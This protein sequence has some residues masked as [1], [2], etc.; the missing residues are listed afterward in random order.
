M[1]I[2]SS[3]RKG[4]L[5]TGR[6]PPPVSKALGF[7]PPGKEGMYLT[8]TIHIALL[9]LW[10]VLT[11][12]NLVDSVY[13]PSPSKLFAAFDSFIVPDLDD[14]ISRGLFQYYSFGTQVLF[15]MTRIYASFAV[16]SV[17]AVFVGMLAS[18]SRW[19]GKPFETY[20]GFICVIP[21]I[22][23][24]SYM[25]AVAIFGVP[26]VLFLTLLF[27]FC[28]VANASYEVANDKKYR[29]YR[30]AAKA[31]GLSA[32]KILFLVEIP[33]AASPLLGILR[34]E[35]FTTIGT[36]Y[37]AEYFLA[38]SGLGPILNAMQQGP[39]MAGLIAVAVTCLLTMLPGHF[40]LSWLA[41]RLGGA[42]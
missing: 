20:I 34:V 21:R 19:L 37:F 8:W 2:P 32:V 27:T 39:N 22:V 28:Y 9:M 33:M 36:V 18:K 11:E 30:D 14:P 5:L 29:P 15:T 16:A 25:M 1:S 26:G 7:I 41:R 24:A 40:A 10:G 42:Q 6:E 35:L 31:L 17:F 38:Q 13:L 3:L 23:V 4:E 12:T